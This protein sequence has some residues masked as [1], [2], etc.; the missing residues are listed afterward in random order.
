MSIDK[1]D[2]RSTR[3]DDAGAPR[4]RRDLG[5]RVS[6]VRPPLDS[7]D[8]A[9]DDGAGPA[10]GLREVSVEVLEHA[11]GHGQAGTQEDRQDVAEPRRDDRR[12]V[13][14]NHCGRRV[15]TR[16][17]GAMWGHMAGGVECLGPK[18]C[19]YSLPKTR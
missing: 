7:E 14:C 4:D 11:E 5:L 17:S 13:T 8:A 6:S 12:R 15:L 2:E 9:G 3:N 10:E 16:W 19:D 18:T 1:R